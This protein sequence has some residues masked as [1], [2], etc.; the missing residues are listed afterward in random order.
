MTWKRFCQ[1]GSASRDKPIKIATALSRLY[2]RWTCSWVLNM[3][4]FRTRTSFFGTDRTTIFVSSQHGWKFFIVDLQNHGWHS[5]DAFWKVTLNILLKSSKLY[6][7]DELYCLTCAV[8]PRLS[9]CHLFSCSTNFS[10]QRASC[11]L[12]SSLKLALIWKKRSV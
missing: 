7:I 2:T 12:S 9:A 8:I 11:A 5:D 3:F 6:C 4:S 10:C 1:C